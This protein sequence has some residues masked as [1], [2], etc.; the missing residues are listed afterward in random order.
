MPLYATLPLKSILGFFLLLSLYTNTEITAQVVINEGSNKNYLSYKDEDGKYPDWIEIYN[1]GADTVHLQG[2]TLTDDISNP[3]RWV[4][5]NVRLAPGEYKVVFCS[6]NDRKPVTGFK[7]VLT[8]S[9]FKAVPGWNTHQFSE[10]FY[11]DGSSNILLN[12]CSYSGVGYTTNSVFN[13]T[14]KPYASTLFAVQD[15]SPF[16]CFAEYGF[17]TDVRPNIRF[18]DI[19]IDTG[20][21]Q[22]SATDYP[23]P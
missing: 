8:A 19:A 22:N 11:W 4:F 1:P 20:I 12:V 9:P 2:Y 15:G 10:P 17:K 5:P 21:V 16:I 3:S 13:Q 7:H 23:A 6:G 18:N 14:R